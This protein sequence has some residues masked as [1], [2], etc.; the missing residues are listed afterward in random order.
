MVERSDTTGIECP[1]IPTTPE[2]SQIRYRCEWL[3]GELG[4]TDPTLG[5]EAPSLF[6]ASCRTRT[7]KYRNRFD[8]WAY[9]VL[10]G[11]PLPALPLWYA[12]NR[13]VTLDLEGSYE[14]TCQLLGIG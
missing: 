10:L 11:Q 4:V 14:D 8:A 13:M 9:S 12:P 5:A 2:G 1:I 7:H 3:L 6:A